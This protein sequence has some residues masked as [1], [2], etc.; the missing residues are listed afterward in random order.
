MNFILGLSCGVL[1]GLFVI[2][3]IRNF[4]GGDSDK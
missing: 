2:K 3:Y 1:V 4:L